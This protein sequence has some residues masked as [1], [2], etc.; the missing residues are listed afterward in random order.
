MSNLLCPV[1]SDNIYSS[2]LQSPSL[3]QFHGYR[4]QSHLLG[5]CQT[6]THTVAFSLCIQCTYSL[7]R[8]E[9]MTDTNISYNTIQWSGHQDGHFLWDWSTCQPAAGVVWELAVLLVGLLVKAIG[10][11]SLYSHGNSSGSS[12][13]QWQDRW[14]HF[15]CR[16][17]FCYITRALF[18]VQSSFQAAAQLVSTYSTTSQQCL[19]VVVMSYN[20]LWPLL[21]QSCL[22]YHQKAKSIS[23]RTFLSP[24]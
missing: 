5:Q 12:Y 6:N 7:S 8:T 20:A 14:W 2:G 10:L 19:E 16:I 3:A 24:F 22:G 17:V 21:G 15:Y 9:T 11:Q 4:Q 18:V 1:W 13:F 23:Y